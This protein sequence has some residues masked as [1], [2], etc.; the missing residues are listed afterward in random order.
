MDE[1]LIVVEAIVKN[2]CASANRGFHCQK[3]RKSEIFE[4]RGDRTSDDFAGS[5]H[6]GDLYAYVPADDDGRP[7]KDKYVYGGKLV[8]DLYFGYKLSKNLTAFI[9]ADNLFNVHPD[10]GIAPGARF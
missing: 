9:G 7:V 8:N 5:F 2:A 6:R 3:R 4:N 1:D 10:L